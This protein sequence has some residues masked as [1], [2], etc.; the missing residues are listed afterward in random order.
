MTPLVDVRN[1]VK[2]FYR[3]GGALFGRGRAV[4]AVDDVSFSIREG[5]I[6][7]LVGES[8]RKSVV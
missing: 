7:G 5:E 1:L 6:L 4:R 3:P 2:E 8:D